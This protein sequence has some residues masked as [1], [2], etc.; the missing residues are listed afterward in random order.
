MHVVYTSQGPRDCKG[1]LVIYGYLMEKVV[2]KATKTGISSCWVINTQF[3]KIKFKPPFLDNHTQYML[4][5]VKF[6]LPQR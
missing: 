1:Q 4:S 3:N 2:L 6:Y 5:L